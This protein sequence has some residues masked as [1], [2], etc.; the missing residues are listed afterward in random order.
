[1]YTP[2]NHQLYDVQICCDHL[3]CYNGSTFFGNKTLKMSGTEYEFFP[4]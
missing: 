4:Q 1:M 3:D 2:V